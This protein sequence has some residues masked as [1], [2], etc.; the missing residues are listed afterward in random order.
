MTNLTSW[1]KTSRD[2]N[3]LNRCEK[4]ENFSRTL[5]IPMFPGERSFPF[6]RNHS[7]RRFSRLAR[8]RET[9]ES[10]W[11]I[12]QNLFPRYIRRLE[13]SRS[14]T[15]S[16]IF[17]HSMWDPRN[18]FISFIIIKISSFNSFPKA[19]DTSHFL[20]LKR[21]FVFEISIQA[22]I[23]FQNLKHKFIY[24]ISSFNWFPKAR[25]LTHP[26]D[27]NLQFIFTILSI[28]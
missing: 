22:S 13:F 20:N 1:K 26:T 18:I 15:M 28:N 27:F 25:A 7:S 8:R 11:I 3:L 9:E 14:L 4:S 12:Y 16:W 17:T 24:W 19:R 5:C 10:G 21:Q 2:V 23:H 6:K